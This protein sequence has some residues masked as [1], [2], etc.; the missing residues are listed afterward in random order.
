M[1][2]FRTT[3]LGRLINQNMFLIAIAIGAIIIIIVGIQF[4]DEQAKKSREEEVV[5]T[6]VIATDS[7]S[8][9][10]ISGGK[11]SEKENTNN[12][13]V[14]DSFMEYCNSGEIEKAYELISDDCKEELYPTIEQF[15]K[16]YWG[17]IFTTSK[18][19]S[20][21]SWIS[22]YDTFTYKVKILEDMLATGKYDKSAIIEDYYTIIPTENGD[23]I[24]INSY[25][26][27]EEINKTVEENGNK[28]TIVNKQVYMDYEVY[29]IEVQNN[30]Q[31]TIVLDSKE[32][33]RNTYLIGENEVKYSS[34]IDEVLDEDL[35]INAGQTKKIEIKFNKMYNPSIKIK[36]VVFTDIIENYEEYLNSSDKNKYEGRKTIIVSI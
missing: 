19:H 2:D 9:T 12:K 17:H 10:I 7:S 30:S 5:N 29:T 15:K 14:I 6:T 13:I 22:D 27:K 25:I 11:V 26:K 36:Q 24:N 28:Y 31:E 1:F 16:L 3:R 4:L 33:L 20:M 23:K 35:R 8:E 21:Q 32:T 18:S 34:Y